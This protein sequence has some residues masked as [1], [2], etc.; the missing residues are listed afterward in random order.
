M[1]W[2]GTI[3]SPIAPPLKK[4]DNNNNNNNNKKQEA[5]SKKQEQ[6]I[7]IY[8]VE[9]QQI[10]TWWS[11]RPSTSFIFI[12]LILT[13]WT[14]SCFLWSL[15]THSSLLTFFLNFFSIFL[16][17]IF[18]T[19]ILLWNKLFLSI[20]IW[21]KKHR[22]HVSITNKR[23]ICIFTSHKNGPFNIY[24]EL[25][26]LYPNLSLER[27]YS[28]LVLLSLYVVKQFLPLYTWQTTSYASL[29]PQGTVGTLLRHAW[30]PPKIWSKTFYLGWLLMNKLNGSVLTIIQSLSAYQM[31]LFH[32]KF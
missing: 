11:A 14:C 24:F 31:H 18:R 12:F 21:K 5:R 13:N 15:C 29:C 30:N 1:L 9:S 26:I 4:H 17:A 6:S 20:L 25:F 28:V 8:T 27:I 3:P 2:K 32:L 23:G 7:S 10:L 22:N 19:A 16:W